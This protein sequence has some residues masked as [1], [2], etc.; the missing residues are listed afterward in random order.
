MKRLFTLLL[1]SFAAVVLGGFDNVGGTVLAALAVAI[2]Q[3]LL[4][5][6]VNHDYSEAYPYIILLV[7]L[8]L[9]PAGLIRQSTSVRY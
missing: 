6:Y 2:T 7:V 9:R 1:A 3:Q 5:G 8:I 4:T